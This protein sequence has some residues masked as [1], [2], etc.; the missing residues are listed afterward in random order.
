MTKGHLLLFNSGF[1]KFLRFSVQLAIKARIHSVQV[2]FPGELKDLLSYV[3]FSKSLTFF[4]SSLS[5]DSFPKV[6]AL[7]ERCP[8]TNGSKLRAA[9]QA[10]CWFSITISD[11]NSQ[12]SIVWMLM[13]WLF[14]SVFSFL[15]TTSTF[16]STTQHD[17]VNLRTIVPDGQ[18]FFS[19]KTLGIPSFSC[20][21]KH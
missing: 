16:Q 11:A 15:L 7:R 12:V 3:S 4:D 21:D 2:D 9:S 20:S 6:L 10:S 5:T 13:I 17:A 1:P 14:F 8:E 19:A 18:I